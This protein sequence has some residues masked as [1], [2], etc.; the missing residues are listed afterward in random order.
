MAFATLN[1]QSASMGG[2]KVYCGDWTGNQGDASGTM[3]LAGG[4]VY[5]AHFENQD[6]DQQKEFPLVDVSVSSGTIT[7]TIHNHMD[8]TNGRFFVVYA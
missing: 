6:T 5:Q 8:V 3:T 4:R 1:A 7:L 2:V